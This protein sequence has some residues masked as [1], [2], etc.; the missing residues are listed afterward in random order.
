MYTDILSLFDR[1]FKE[2][3]VT[4][5]YDEDLLSQ[6]TLANYKFYVFSNGDLK[7]WR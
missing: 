3:I 1:G 4:A 2:V 7:I 6:L 5:G